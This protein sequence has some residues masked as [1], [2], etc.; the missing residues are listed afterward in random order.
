MHT[1]FSKTLA[2]NRLLIFFFIYHILH[3]LKVN[4]TWSLVRVII[5]IKIFMIFCIHNKLFECIEN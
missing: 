2:Y 5:L 3:I 1:L 4:M